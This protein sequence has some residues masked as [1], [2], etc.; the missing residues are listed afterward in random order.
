MDD[1]TANQG[2]TQE[3]AGSLTSAY[4]PQ[5]EEETNIEGTFTAIVD[6]VELRYS[7]SKNEP[8]LRWQFVIDDPR[9][10]DADGQKLFHNT[11]LVGKG[12]F[13]F[14]EA[15][16]A[17]EIPEENHAN[18]QVSDVV[19][20]RVLISVSMDEYQGKSRPQVD[21]MHVHPKGPEVEGGGAQRNKKTEIPF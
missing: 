11:M 18:L 14:K 8:M 12:T 20:K 2:A 4:R 16:E 3:N 17:L 1:P 10:D 6:E 21:S 5:D 19:G 15:M 13:K 7:K 9:D